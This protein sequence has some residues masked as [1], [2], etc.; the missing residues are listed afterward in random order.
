MWLLDKMLRKLV[1]QGQLVLTDYDGRVYTYG[2][3]DPA[4]RIRLTD[5]GAAFHIARDPRVGAGEAYMDGRLVIE[6]PHDIRDFV[7]F[8]MGQKA[9]GKI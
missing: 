9:G 2:S 5:K 4:L 8:V 6:P 3:G 1:R 7:L